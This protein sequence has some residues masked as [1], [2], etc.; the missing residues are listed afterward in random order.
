MYYIIDLDLN[1]FGIEIFLDMQMYLNVL[2]DRMRKRDGGQQTVK[3]SQPSDAS[4]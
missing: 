2:F 3:S 4:H 1:D